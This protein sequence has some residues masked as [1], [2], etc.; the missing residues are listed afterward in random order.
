MRLKAPINA[1]RDVGFFRFFMRAGIPK[2][3]NQVPATA[4]NDVLTLAPVKMHRRHLA[5]ANVHDFFGV[6]F[7]IGCAVG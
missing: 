5:I 4:I 2:F 7:F 6:A 1:N 3:Y